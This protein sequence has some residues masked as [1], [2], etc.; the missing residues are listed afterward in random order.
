MTS[1]QVHT[2]LT[3]GEGPGDVIHVGTADGAVITVKRDEI[4]ERLPQTVSIMPDRL[5]D[6]LAPGE[7]RDLLAFLESLK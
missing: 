1:G 7:F 4:E 5:E 3:V 2:G 6:R